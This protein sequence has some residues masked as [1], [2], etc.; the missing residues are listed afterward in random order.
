MVFLG[1]GGVSDEQGTPVEKSKG[2]LSSELVHDES[3]DRN[4]VVTLEGVNRGEYFSEIRFRGSPIR[5]ARKITTQ[6]LW[7]VTGSFTCVVTFVERSYFSEI[8]VRMRVPR[9]SRRCSRDTHPES[10]FTK[11]TSIQR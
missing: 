3:H 7:D 1:G 11:D 9:E 4:P 8:L 2:P 5:F 6:L 10:Y